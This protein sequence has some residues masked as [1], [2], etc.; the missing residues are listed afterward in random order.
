MT[1]IGFLR[2]GPSP[3]LIVGF[4]QGLRELGRIEGQDCVIDLW[5][6]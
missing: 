1:R 3:A 2:V 6:M 5:L 4:Q